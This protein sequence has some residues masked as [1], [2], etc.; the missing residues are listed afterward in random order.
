MATL[1]AIGYT[2]QGTAE[3]ARETVAKLESDL[4]IQA[5]QVA[6]ISRDLDGKY[7]VHRVPTRRWLRIQS[8][9][10][11]RVTPGMCVATRRGSRV[12]SGRPV[13]AAW[14]PIRKSGRIASRRPPARR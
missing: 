5:D 12:R 11:M 6:T 10:L 8:S 1:V 13:T 2:D 3:Q 14:A 7:H 4:V 9:G